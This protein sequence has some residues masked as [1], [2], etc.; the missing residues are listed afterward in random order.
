MLVNNA[1]YSLL[2]GIEEASRAE[3]SAQFAVNVLAPV[4]A[5][6]AV[7]PH[8]RARG[9]GHVINITSVSG[10]AP[11][12]G[13]GVYGAS[14]YALEGIGQT[15]AQEVEPLGVRVTNVEPGSIRT[16][17]AGRSQRVVANK[18]DA[19]ADGPVR[20]AERILSGGHGLEAG[21]PARMA[22]A[23]LKIAG[24]PDAPRQLLLGAD[25]VHYAFQAAARF[26]EEFGR[27]AELS[28]STGH[29]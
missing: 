23:I 24:S 5:I 12:A 16:D 20:E 11:W 10:L 18:L 2:G 3:I 25:A 15:L 27:F 29:V 1:G 7:L 4:A 19:Y 6:Q 13:T 9:A 22:A 17:F 8:F 21:D 14:K 28:L 26:Q